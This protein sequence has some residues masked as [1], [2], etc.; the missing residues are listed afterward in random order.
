MT[1][2]KGYVII[3]MSNERTTKKQNGGKTLDKRQLRRI[4]ANGGATLNADGDEVTFANG[5]QV[6][7]RDCYII[8]VERVNLICKKTN[9]L[10][11]SLNKGEFVGLWID[12]GKIYI[13]ISIRIRKQE[14][15]ERIGRGL[16]QLAIYDWSADACI[17]L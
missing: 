4:I 12:D 13:D 15:A 7:K 5:F 3:W 16:K 6:S 14:K 2:Q 8:A 1:S 17:T 10:L 11:R 9:A